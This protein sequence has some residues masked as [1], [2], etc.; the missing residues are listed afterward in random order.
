[1][2]IGSG[3]CNRI[4]HKLVDAASGP[5]VP[6]NRNLYLK[7]ARRARFTTTPEAQVAVRPNDGGVTI[8]IWLAIPVVSQET[9]KIISSSGED[10]A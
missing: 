1:M 6:M 7:K 8:T 3:R 5:A 9:R 10:H 4:C 2:P